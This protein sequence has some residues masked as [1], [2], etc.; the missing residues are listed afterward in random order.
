VIV[1]SGVASA[2]YED[3]KML[4][5]TTT[6]TFGTLLGI[7]TAGLMFTQGKFGELTGE[8]SEKSPHYLKNVLSLEET[9]SIGE[10]LLALK[11][12]FVTLAD[13]TEVLEE[14][15]L[16]KRIVRKCSSMFVDVAV[17]LN[18][19]L[20]QE[21]LTGTGLLISEMSSEERE[22]YH[23]RWRMVKRDWHVLTLIKQIVDA[24]EATTVIPAT[25]MKLEPS[26]H[27]ELAS[28]LPI[29]RLK[30][31]VD[32]SSERVHLDV[33]KRLRELE[34][35][36][37]KIIVRFHE[38]RIPQLLT[39]MEQANVVRGKYFYL[40]LIFIAAPT[41]VNLLIL[42]QFSGA[43]ILFLR[44]VVGLTSVLAILGVVILLFYIYEILNV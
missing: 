44:V 6:A 1:F 32:K 27:S 36:I 42:P 9:R 19:K 13:A 37:D 4:I 10:S 40:S 26:L 18:L 24:W 14:K 29:L 22:K 8:L 31:N 34:D 20:R 38:D 41:L 30:E 25:R 11:R 16:Y 7:I 5:E 3:L 43:A 21:R 17:L 28:S 33:G 39:Q 35:K 12:V 15:E 2:D 23:E